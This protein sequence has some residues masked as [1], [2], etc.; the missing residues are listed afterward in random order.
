MLTAPIF[1]TESMEL[2]ELFQRN[3]MF[4]VSRVSYLSRADLE[5]MLAMFEAAG[6][7]RQ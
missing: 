6:E 5:R 4:D 2:A 3:A 1:V 7:S